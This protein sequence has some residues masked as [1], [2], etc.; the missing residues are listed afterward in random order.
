MGEVGA[1]TWHMYLFLAEIND[2]F[3]PGKNSNLQSSELSLRLLTSCPCSYWR[4]S[5]S[6][7]WS[8]KWVRIW[9]NEHS[10]CIFSC[11]CCAGLN[12]SILCGGGKVKVALWRSEIL[13][14]Y[15]VAHTRKVIQWSRNAEG[16]KKQINNKGVG[17]RGKKMQWG[18]GERNWEEKIMCCGIFSY[19]K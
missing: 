11:C 1:N 5:E 12:Y 2:I 18:V 9:Y 7:T 10:H 4:S 19:L 3:L 17:R 13:S 14:F 16:T 6:P 15:F 8:S